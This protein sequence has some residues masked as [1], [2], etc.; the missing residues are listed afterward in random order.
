[1]PSP[2]VGRAAEGETG[3]TAVTDTHVLEWRRPATTADIVCHVIG[4]SK[5]Q[6]PSSTRRPT[7]QALRAK[8]IEAIGAPILAVL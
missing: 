3:F 2:A 4:C 8:A 1:V 5:L 6:P 7:G